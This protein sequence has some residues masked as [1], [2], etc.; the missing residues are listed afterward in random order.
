MQI[1]IDAELSKLGHEGNHVMQR[2]PEPIDAPGNHDVKLA[3]RRILV[4]AI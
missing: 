4:K 3:P 1:Q 2:P